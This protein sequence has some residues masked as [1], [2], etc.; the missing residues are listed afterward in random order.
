MAEILFIVTVIFV[1]YVVY[2]VVGDIGKKEATEE[3]AVPTKKPAAKATA[4]PAAKPEPKPAAKPAAKPAESSEGSN[5]VRNP[6]T[7]ETAVIPSN[8]RFTKRWIK[9]AL[10]EEG[11]LDKVYKNTELDDAASAKVKEALAKF[12]GLK[13][14]QA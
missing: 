4:K 13:K 8:Y 11:L 2:S 12:K 7:G 9:E 3:P 5:E 6:A 14:Y 1:A 10:V